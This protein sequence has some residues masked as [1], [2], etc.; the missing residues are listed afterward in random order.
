VFCKKCYSRLANV[1]CEKCPQ[2]GRAFNPLDPRTY[3]R[4]PFPSAGQII[5]HVVATTL[6]GAGVALV[7]AAFQVTRTSG[8]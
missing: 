1:D 4:R 7:V 3:L 8:H 6:V 5:G 2:C